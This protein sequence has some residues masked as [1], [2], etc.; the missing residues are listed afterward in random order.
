MKAFPVEN[1]APFFPSPGQRPGHPV[2]WCRSQP[3]SWTVLAAAE[4]LG[5]PSDQLGMLENSD[6]L[7]YGNYW[8]LVFAD[9]VTL[10]RH[11][12]LVWRNQRSQNR[13]AQRRLQVYQSQ[14][15]AV[16]TGRNTARD[17][18]RRNT[19]LFFI[20]GTAQARRDPVCIDDWIEG[21]RDL[22]R[23]ITGWRPSEEY[24]RHEFRHL[25]DRVALATH[26]VSIR[27]GIHKRKLDPWSL[28]TVQNFLDSLE[29]PKAEARKWDARLCG[30]KEY[31]PGYCLSRRWINQFLDITDLES[32]LCQMRTLGDPEHAR[33]R[34][35]ATR[36]RI[37]RLRRKLTKRQKLQLENGPL[38][39][40][41]NLTS[42]RIER[43][44]EPAMAALRMLAATLRRTGT[45]GK[46][47]YV[48][49]DPEFLQSQTS[50]Q[51]N[52]T[53]ACHERAGDTQECIRLRQDWQKKKR[54]RHTRPL[55][56]FQAI[57]E[58]MQRLSGYSEKPIL[59]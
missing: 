17:F 2:R 36:Q 13:A 4:G 10:A 22:H 9:T 31:H 37:C 40:T 23:R 27:E 51:K 11:R 32:R 41:R 25:L 30:K 38:V 15:N 48:S 1:K 57:L 12:F 5:L 24:I 18:V 26:G 46:I 35:A 14:G 39:I 56:G 33:R 58:V 6:F 16:P 21:L 53:Q 52:W 20:L 54:E 50:R 7:Q 49:P 47:Y 8:D 34:A 59:A 42:P 3:E 29:D 19:R 43:Y 45:P 44:L 55:E 28:W